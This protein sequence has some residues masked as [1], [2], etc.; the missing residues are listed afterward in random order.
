[1]KFPVFLLGLIVSSV[2]IGIGLWLEGVSIGKSMLWVLIAFG[3]G[4]LLYVGMIAVL[5]ALEKKSLRKTS[6]AQDTKAE[7][8]RGLAP[9]QDRHV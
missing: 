4:Q 1:M 7:N 5:A 8:V 2:G 9:E 3:V 6:Q